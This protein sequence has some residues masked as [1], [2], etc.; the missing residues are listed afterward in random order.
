MKQQRSTPEDEK[1]KATKKKIISIN[2]IINFDIY[3]ESENRD[4]AIS[5]LF[6]INDIMKLEFDEFTE[7]DFAIPELCREESRA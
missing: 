3:N 2:I 4:N 5:G 1:L 6:R 7:R